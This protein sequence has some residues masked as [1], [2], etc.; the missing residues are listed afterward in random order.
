MHLHSRQDRHRWRSKREG[1]GHGWP[2]SSLGFNAE[3]CRCWREASR[4]DFPRHDLKVVSS[5]EADDSEAPPQVPHVRQCVDEIHQYSGAN[6]DLGAASNPCDRNGRSVRE[7][8]QQCENRLAPLRSS[9][10]PV[11]LRGRV[12][13]RD[14]AL[15]GIAIQRCIIVSVSGRPP[16]QREHLPWIAYHGA[17]KSSCFA[18]SL[19]PFDPIPHAF[20]DSGVF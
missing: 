11:G 17:G 1:V 2:E 19:G 6:C 10:A 15:I 8:A 3:L 5:Q 7:L 9:I 18:F 4:A 16:C 12:V 20:V 13:D 14:D